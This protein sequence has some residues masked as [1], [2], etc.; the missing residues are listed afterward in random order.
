MNKITYAGGY[1]GSQLTLMINLTDWGEGWKALEI[2]VKNRRKILE[3]LDQK[4]NMYNANS[5]YRRNIGP[6][7]N[8]DVWLMDQLVM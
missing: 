3:R 5:E 2:P 1:H 7:E 4:I 8:V 6:G